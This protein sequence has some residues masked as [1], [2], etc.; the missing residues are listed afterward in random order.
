MLSSVLNNKRAV[1]VNIAIIRAFVKMRHILDSHADLARKLQELE[2]KY[3]TRFKVVFDELRAMREFQ[4][5]KE[6]PRP[7]IGFKP[8]DD[9]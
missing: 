3:D 5:R 1:Q 4:P 9:N 8:K 2:K 6:P 7:A